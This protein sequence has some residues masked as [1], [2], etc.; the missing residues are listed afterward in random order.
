MKKILVIAFLAVSLFSF[1]YLVDSQY[2][3][4]TYP[5]DQIERDLALIKQK[6]YNFVI[7]VPAEV[8][9]VAGEEVAINAS[10]NNLGQFTLR[11]FNLTLGDLPFEYQITPKLSEIKIVRDWNPK[12]GLYK[13]PTYFQIKIKVPADAVGAHLVNVKGQELF[14]WR[15]ASNSSS[16]ILKISN[17]TVIIQP[18]ITVSRILVPDQIKEN[19][20]FNISFLVNNENIFKQQVNISLSIPSD[21]SA[22]AV[23]QSFLIAPNSAA[24]VY[25]TV[26]PTNTSGN[27][28]VTV[29][30][31]FKEKIFTIVRDGP[32]LIPEVEK[33]VAENVTEAKPAAE[34]KQPVT[35]FAAL[36]QFIRNMSPILIAIVV[37]VIIIIVWFIVKLIR[38]YS[39]RKKPESIKH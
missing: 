27:I 37:L 32:Y 4:T 26:T 6:F 2:S 19:E 8:E 9:A 17:P 20:P 38:F 14:S 33:P 30:Y 5:K 24:A 12:Q 3:S 1:A 23:Q 21:W 28:S 22:D 35:G 10:V 36:V 25:Y 16:F 15:K 29:N 18:N 34:E 11:D 7:S 13:V 31:P 39:G